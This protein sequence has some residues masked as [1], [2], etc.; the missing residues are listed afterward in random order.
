MATT[1]LLSAKSIIKPSLEKIIP[2]IT[3]SMI[4][5]TCHRVSFSYGD[6]LELDFG[7][8]TPYEH[9]KLAQGLRLGR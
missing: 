9:P 8:M 7:E 3:Q 6:E 4:G 1:S 2:S 5:A